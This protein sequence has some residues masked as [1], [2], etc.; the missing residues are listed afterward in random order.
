M[1]GYLLKKSLSRDLKDEKDNIH[2]SCS[3]NRF[4][5]E[6]DAAYFKIFQNDSKKKLINVTAISLIKDIQINNLIKDYEKSSKDQNHVI[7]EKFGDN[8]TF[9]IELIENKFVYLRASTPLEALEWVNHLNSIKNSPTIIS[10]INQSKDLPT[11]IE[12][13]VKLT[14]VSSET[15]ISIDECDHM[16]GGLP[17]SPKR[18]DCARPSRKSIISPRNEKTQHGDM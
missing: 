8:I 17:I 16:N 6:T 13:N 1:K 3:W 4:Y 7:N 12:A 15:K 14:T 18:R 5:F 9:H 2:I 11:T 10:T